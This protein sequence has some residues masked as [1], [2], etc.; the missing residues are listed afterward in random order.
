MSS[1]A[2]KICNGSDADAFYGLYRETL[3]F[4]APYFFDPYMLYLEID[5]PPNER[6][7]QP[8][9]KILKTVTDGLQD[10]YDDKLDELFLEEPP[11]VGKTTE[12]LLFMSWV[13][14]RNSELSNL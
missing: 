2:L 3:L 11:R 4:D 5:R 6:F 9:R 13:A 12:L 14:G 1:N 10:L 8:R 7:Y